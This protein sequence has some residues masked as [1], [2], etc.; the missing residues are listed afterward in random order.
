MAVNLSPVGGV[1][2]QFFDNSGQVLTGGKLY[3]Y[4]AGTTTPAATYTTNSGLTA[5]SNPIV[6]NA[7]GRVA[8]SGEIWLSD[9]VNYKFVLQDQNGVQIAVYDNVTG[10]N[11]NF[12]NY[13]LQAQ[14]FT[15]TQGQTAFTLTGGLQYI[16]ATNNLAVF[17]NGSK[18]IV[19]TNYLET[20]TTVFTFLTGLNVGDVVE[21]VLSTTVA[22]NVTNAVNVAYNPP[23]T[24][25]VATNVQARLAQTIS[26]KDFGAV[27]DG[28]T[29]DTAA[30][31]AAIN[32]CA[33]FFQWPALIIP[34]KCKITSSVNINRLVDT[35]TSDFIIRG[36]GAGA[37]FYTT[38]AI[39]VFDSTIAYGTAN[40]WGA[41]APSSENVVFDSIQFETSAVSNASYAM[42]GKFLRIKFLNCRF[43]GMK[44]AN[45]TTAY[46]Q[47]WH[48]LNCT[49]RY[50]TTQTFLVGLGSFDVSFL[51]NIIENNYRLFYSAP[52]S[53]GGNAGFRLID[54]VI[55]GTTVVSGVGTLGMTGATTCVIAH[56]HIEQNITADFNFS[57]GTSVASTDVLIE[58]NYIVCDSPNVSFYHWT[59]ANVT[60]I[61]NT[62]AST[63]GTA[64]QL[65]NQVNRITNFI[66]LNDNILNSGTL[67]DAT[68]YSTVNG[69]YR[70]GGAIAAW[71][72]S[73][74]QI[75]KSTAGNFGVNIVPQ[76]TSKLTVKGA[77]QTSS[78]FA[79]ILYDSAGN[80][81]SAFRNDR[82]I[83]LPALQNYANDAAAAAAGLP[84]GYLYRNGSVVQIRVT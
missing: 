43:Q 41:F 12:I 81:I 26:V 44:A 54:N 64:G 22:T 36:Q 2:A 10:I 4:L 83:T 24:S 82:Q 25:S 34:G 68:N 9:S 7:A 3:S 56:N 32:Y 59:N 16:V 45:A 55:E 60:S 78:N 48:F 29:D 71:T 73:S 33:T 75:T 37:G 50:C 74:N 42:T 17:V 38:S 80:T 63:G 58:G 1:A 84:V 49:I 77:D 35:T 6:L 53:P 15:A 51:H 70:A 20:S 28:T 57:V 27:C 19:G 18:Q 30:V 72:D 39:T 67:S 8:D 5:N 14:T 69:V 65:H 40:S 62:L 66:S 46:L 47:T 61:G 11:S 31:Q 52:N 79:L 23:F 76:S 13:T 21:A